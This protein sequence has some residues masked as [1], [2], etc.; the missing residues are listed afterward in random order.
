MLNQVCVGYLHENK[1][2]EASIDRV[3][4]DGSAYFGVDVFDSIGD[5]LAGSVHIEDRGRSI[6]AYSVQLIALAGD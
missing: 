6:E 2:V 1:H 4:G 3:R 5:V